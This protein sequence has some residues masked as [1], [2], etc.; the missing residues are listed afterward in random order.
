MCA[1]STYNNAQDLV[2]ESTEK[3]RDLLYNIKGESRTVQ[4]PEDVRA[5]WEKVMGKPW[6]SPAAKKDDKKDDQDDPDTSNEDN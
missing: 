2:S 3:F 4:T 6:P 1:G 5:M